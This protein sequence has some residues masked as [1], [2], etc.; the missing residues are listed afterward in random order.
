MARAMSPAR[1]K[2]LTS[3]D[4]TDVN[5][6]SRAQL[7]EIVKPLQV[8]AQRRM[9]SLQKS[10]IYSAAAESWKGSRA[11]FQNVTTK[12]K[13]GELRSA[14]SQLK[15]FTGRKSSTVTG[16]KAVR[17]A[18]NKMIGGP[19]PKNMEKFFW[20]T[21][22]EFKSQSGSYLKKTENDTERNKRAMQDLRKIVLRGRYGDD[23]QG[24][25]NRLTEIAHKKEEA[26]AFARAE[27][28]LLEEEDFYYP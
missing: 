26:I 15:Q 7:R 11:I 14:Y 4:A 27:D 21:W 18:R 5:R 1:L 17:A 25:I 10:D 3:Y 20:D 2:K 24:I 16:A 8:E 19:I 6:M 13:L 23:K 28:E 9:E 12:T 22:E